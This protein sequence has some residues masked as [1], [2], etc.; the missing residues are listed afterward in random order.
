MK[1]HVKLCLC[2][3]NCFLTCSQTSI[4]TPCQV[5]SLHLGLVLTVPVLL[6]GWWSSVFW[7]PELL[8]TSWLSCA[9]V[10]YKLQNNIN[11]Y[12]ECSFH[13]D[14][15]VFW[16]RD[17]LTC[18]VCIQDWGPAILAAGADIIWRGMAGKGNISI[19]QS[20]IP[21]GLWVRAFCCSCFQAWLYQA[22][23]W[24]S[25]ARN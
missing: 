4:L 15:K 18:Y 16:G 8:N 10:S 13:L 21:C 7:E 2:H 22:V 6:I 12:T 1:L 5:A 9:C 25:A 3:R 23:P 19:G 20:L 11:H 17:E 14:W 24:A